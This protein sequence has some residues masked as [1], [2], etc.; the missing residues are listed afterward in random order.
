M[1][2][3]NPVLVC[4][5]RR[6]PQLFGKDG[7]AILNQALYGTQEAGRCWE[8]F[9][10]D[11]VIIPLGF[12]H[13][14]AQD[15]VYIRYVEVNG[16]RKVDAVVYVHVDDVLIFSGESSADAIAA[17][18]DAK[19][20]FKDKPY[21]P[22]RFCGIDFEVTELGIFL[23]QPHLTKGLEIPESTT[24]IDK[25]LPLNATERYHDDDNAKHK[26]DVRGHAQFRKVTGG[27]LYIQLTRPD[28]L[29][30]MSFHGRSCHSPTES[31]WRL[32]TQSVQYA[33]QTSEYGLYYPSREAIRRGHKPGFTTRGNDTPADYYA[34]D[35]SARTQQ[36]DIYVDASFLLQCAQTGY[37]I[38]LNGCLIDMRSVR[39]KRQ[40]SSTTKAELN[41]IFD[42]IDALYVNQWLANELLMFH[43]TDVTTMWSDSLNL[44]QAFNTDHPKMN[45][46]SM[47]MHVLQIRRLIDNL[48]F[49]ET[50]IDVPREQLPN[51]HAKYLEAQTQ[52]G[53]IPTETK[54]EE[55]GTRQ[56]AFLFAIHD[57]T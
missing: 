20:Q 39:Q 47:R 25:P 49:K 22:V 24:K 57:N 1:I 18:I 26:L 30:S 10:R 31:D 27:F 29:F 34:A 48:I 2:G 43:G 9:F 15:S 42:C 12:T 55:A 19:V 33:K 8:L 40:A 50:P 51:T 45:E 14:L 28:C 38:L 41:A 56:G 17:E 54:R 5:P 53:L 4:A 23:G 16:V 36:W 13:S 46:A 3:A 32:L 6:Y 35:G 21:I 11:K 44:V 37:L 52:M 7:V